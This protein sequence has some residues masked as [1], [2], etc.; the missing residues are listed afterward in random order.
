VLSIDL[1][2]LAMEETQNVMTRSQVARRLGVSA[3]YVGQLSAAGR[4]NFVRTPLGRLYDAAEVEAF[5]QERETR[6]E[7]SQ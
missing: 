4:L 1:T 5:A 7:A 6:H 2:I 3:E